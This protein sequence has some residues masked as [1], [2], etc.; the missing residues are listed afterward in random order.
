[1]LAS[2]IDYAIVPRGLC[3][4]VENCFYLTGIKTDH[5]AFFIGMDIN[6]RERGPVYWKL[7]TSLLADYEYI[8]FMNE[9]LDE[10]LGIKN[11]MELDRFWELLKFQISQ[12][13]KQYS[14]N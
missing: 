9:Y 14:R 10:I 3:N 2:R 11:S 12:K 13:S 8:Q 6:P 5:S 7:N 4:T 1:M